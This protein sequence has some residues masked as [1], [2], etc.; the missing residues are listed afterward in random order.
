MSHVSS[1]RYRAN[2]PDNKNSKMEKKLKIS[3]YTKIIAR[4]KNE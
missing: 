3:T 4:A 1:L 2:F